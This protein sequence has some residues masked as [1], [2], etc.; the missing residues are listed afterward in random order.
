MLLLLIGILVVVVITVTTP[1]DLFHS[2]DEISAAIAQKAKRD[3]ASYINT[4]RNNISK[5][6]L[7]N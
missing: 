4:N 6:D 2:P 3:A 7:H 5:S 1:K